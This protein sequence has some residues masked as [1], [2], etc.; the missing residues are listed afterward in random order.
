MK[1]F[2]FKSVLLMAFIAFVCASCST[3]DSI[4]SGKNKKWTLVWSE[5]FDEDTIDPAVWTRIG[6]G[7]SDWN[8]Y[9]SSYDSCYAVKDGKLVLYGMANDGKVPNDTARYLTGGIYT[10]GKKSFENGRI[11]IRARLYGARGEWPAIWMLPENGKWP[12]G[13][14]IDIMERLNHDGI[15]YQTVHTNYTYNLGIKENP[16]SH[17]V[18]K[19]DPDDYNIY[20]VELGADKL[21]FYINGEKTMEYPRVKGKEDLG[22]YP[23][24]KPF[25]LLIDMQLGGQWVGRVNPDELPVKMEVDWVRFYKRL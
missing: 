13:G 14:E 22:Q 9:M 19:I 18:G 3:A 17:T 1:T 4:Q 23:F 5:E 20:G 15:A 10:K 24:N 6:R 8:N 7:K 12:D 25:Y 21:V 2:N 11:E 16:K